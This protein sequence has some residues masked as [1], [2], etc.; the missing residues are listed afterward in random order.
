[1]AFVLLTRRHHVRHRYPPANIGMLGANRTTVRA[2]TIATL[3]L[4]VADHIGG[5][6]RG[7]QGLPAPLAI[8]VQDHPDSG[9]AVSLCIASGCVNFR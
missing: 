2:A 9:E 1:M 6:A 5:S 3:M 4:Q 8:P 7:Y